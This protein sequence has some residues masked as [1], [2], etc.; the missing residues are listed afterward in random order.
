MDDNEQII[1]HN[2]EINRSLAIPDYTRLGDAG[3]AANRIAGNT[4]FK[5]Y[6]SEK[7]ANTIKRHA[8]D[9]ELFAE[10]LLDVGI[11]P[12]KGAD[13][14]TNPG[15][16]E[17]VTW[18]IVEGFIH[19]QLREGYAV[20]SVNARLSTV[21]VYAQMA[22]KAD[23]ID[24]QEGLLIQSVR[25]FSRAG[26]KNVDEQ[27]EQTR[28]D[29][30]SYAY[31]PEG[32]RRSVVVTRSST[33]KE[34]AT[35]LDEGTA[36]LLKQPQNQSPQAH[37]DALLMC[38]LLDHG[39]RASEVTLLTINNIELDL[40]ELYF[41]RPK[42]KGTAH[43]WTAHKMTEE[44]HSIADYYLR[45]LYP[46]SLHPDGP[47]L[48][49]T[50]R[51]RKDGKGGLL[52]PRGLNRVR[53][54]ERVAWLG[55]QAGLSEKLSAHDCRHYCATRMARLGYGVDELMAWFGWTSAQTAMRYITAVDVKER[56]KG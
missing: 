52:L 31:K 45:S 25:G 9:L 29:E 10:Y 14:Q 17:G 54:S 51:L 27:R 36:V 16:W 23:A 20:S 22:V 8:R 7:S 43:E 30:I 55:K 44:L 4:I 15:A 19:W 47:L 6:L 56:Y 3:Q 35:V 26:G 24:R 40:G 49:A 32:K 50:S 48:L 46:P 39:L 28:I 33:K 37:R 53:I 11:M 13:F 42:V 18:G 1:L 34:A 12:D 41:Y 5:R 2:S 21:K 38:L